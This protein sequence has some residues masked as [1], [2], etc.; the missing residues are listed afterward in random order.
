M[1]TLNIN[2]CVHCEHSALG[3]V[4]AKFDQDWSTFL[5]E[6]GDHT[7]I[8]T[9][10]VIITVRWLLLFESFSFEWQMVNELVLI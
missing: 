6:G 4:N 2:K 3:N 10:I 7:N 5:S 9:Y 1:R 8:N